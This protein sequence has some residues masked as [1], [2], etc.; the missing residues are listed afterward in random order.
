MRGGLLN[1]SPT[2]GSIT[3]VYIYFP[4]QN[5]QIKKELIK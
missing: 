2:R 5:E 3:L 1:K 4:P